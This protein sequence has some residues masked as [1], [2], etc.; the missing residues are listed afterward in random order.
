VA[1]LEEVGVNTFNERVTDEPDTTKFRVWKLDIVI[2]DVPLD[3][4][5]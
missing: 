1:G 4:V 2:D 5:I 3:T